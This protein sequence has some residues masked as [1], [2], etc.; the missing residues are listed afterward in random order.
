M[1]ATLTQFPEGPAPGRASVTAPLPKV[2]HYQLERKL[3]EG[4][5]GVVYAA[6]DERL[7][8]RVAIKLVRADLLDAQSREWLWSE[9]R[10]AAA[11]NHPG[12]CQLYDIG[13]VDGQLYLA[14][15]F[16]EGQLV[17]EIIREGPQPVGKA[18]GLTLELLAALSYMHQR[19]LIHRDLK[20]SNLM[21]TQHGLKVLDFG[22]ARRLGG[23]AAKALVLGTAGT[24]QYM[25]PETV[26]NRPVDG[27]ADLFATGAILY[28]LISGR[29]AFTGATIPAVLQAVLRENP[30]ALGGS[31]AAAAVDRVIRRALAKK[32]EDRFASA[33]EFAAALRALGS[34]AGESAPARPIKRLMV[35]PFRVIGRGDDTD[36]LGV[37]LPEALATSLAALDSVVVRSSSAAA[38]FA[39]DPLDLDRLASEGAVDVALTGTLMRAGG[40]VRVATQLIEVPGGAVLKSHTAQESMSDLF[41]VLDQLVSGIVDSLRLEVSPDRSGELRAAAPGSGSAYELFLRANAIG[42]GFQRL[43]EARDLYLECLRRDDSYAPAWARL[44]RCYRLLAKY[45]EEPDR[46]LGLAEAAFERALALQ[47]ELDLAHSLYAQL[48]ADLG[49]SLSALQRLLERVRIHALSADLHAGLVY[50]CRFC[51]L[52]EESIWFHDEARRLDPLFPTSVTHTHFQRGDFRRSLD[53]C[54]SDAGYLD[55]AALDALGQPGEAL[56][57]IDA[58]LSS[59]ALPPLA[60]VYIS[61]L[62]ALL[63]G[64]TAEAL[65]IMRGFDRFFLGPE[66]AIYVA[67]QYI[68]AGQIEE[69]SR[70]LLANVEKGWGNAGFLVSDP[71][72]QAANGDSRFDEAVEKAE[73]AR[74]EALAAFRRWR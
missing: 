15:E 40:K 33:E 36:F 64:Q 51:G 4:G 66:E 47:P 25:A 27:R 7:E 35:L 60:R 22:L 54:S 45:N 59:G 16:L 14:M 72:F 61:S 1:D 2:L 19:G 31:P 67:R 43:V 49:R 74:G 55:A 8:R 10:M 11:I 6:T 26:E 50:A 42:S 71:W 57:R 9:A 20:P 23:S 13:E 32:S 28:E 30:P 53:T 41:Q 37:S 56:Q 17:S 24:P 39:T 44:G 62:R 12:V 68:R 34:A 48:E 5:M 73:A 52:T 18:V 69:G 38:K 21:N 63:I 70:R 46:N 58:R 29:K 3:G 65:E